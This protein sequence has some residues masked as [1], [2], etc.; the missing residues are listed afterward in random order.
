[1]QAT[2]R[3]RDLVIASWET[4]RESLEKAIPAELELAPVDG[5]FRVSLAAF[6]I[7][8]GRVGRFPVPPYAQVNVR[9]PV[10]WNDEPAIYFIAS[11]VSAGGLPGAL[12]GAPFRYARLR[13]EQGAVSAPGRGIS[14]RYRVGDLVDPGSQPAVGLFE[15]D[16]LRELRIRRTEGVWHGA[17]LLEPARAEFL[18][19]LGF[20]PSGSPELLYA[21]H[22]T[23][24]LDVRQR[25][26]SE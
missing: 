24:E 22:R 9:T 17:E 21:A 7:E 11:R 5:R 2:L 4:D 16:G 26:K 23:S 13:V 15:N 14:L 3:V 1:V 20:H 18:F 12:L 25:P 19:A 10:T 8:G 6:R